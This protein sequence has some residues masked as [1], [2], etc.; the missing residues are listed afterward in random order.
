ME[1]TKR[2]ICRTCLLIAFAL[3]LLQSLCGGYAFA[4]GELVS[5]PMNPEFLSYMEA[6]QKERVMATGVT[7]EG[8]GLGLVPS[9]LNLDYL[10][11]INIFGAPQVQ[12]LAEAPLRLG[13][14][15]SYDLRTQGK[16]TPVRDQSTG[17]TCWTFATYGSV[18][19][20]LL[21]GETDDFSENHMKNTHGFDWGYDSGGNGDMA[22]A[23]LARWSGPVNEADDTYN[24]GSG[25]SPPG[26]LPRKHVQG[27]IYIPQR[28]SSSDNDNL[29]N[30][31]MSAGAVYATMYISQD[32]SYYNEGTYAYYY[33][34]AS[35]SNHAVAIV[36]WDDNYSS[37]NFPSAPPGNGAFI[38]RNSWG[39]GFG[40]GG[41]FYISYYDTK[42]AYT[43]NYLFYNTE[44]VTNY[45]RIYQYDPL[46]WTSQIGYSSETGW[47]A[48]IFT[49]QASESLVAVSF[50][51]TSA[52]SPYEIYIYTGV[53]AGVP[54]SGTLAA[55]ETG[56]IQ[57]P[58]Y[59]TIDL[60]SPVYLASGG[61]FS[62]V[63]KL[64]APGT[65]YPISL[66]HWIENYSGSA[67]ASAGQSFISSSGSPWSDLTTLGT[68]DKDNVCLKGFTTEA[69][70][71]LYA[72]WASGLYQENGN[73]WS[74]LHAM[75]PT[76][77][78]ASGSALYATWASGL[79]QWNGTT[80][81][82]IHAAV[83]TNMAA[84]GPN[85]YATWASGLYA[86]N[87][88]TWTKIHA[89]VP[90]AMTAGNNTLYAT[91]ASG[92]YQWNGITWT[93]IH[94]AVPTGMA[95]G[96]TNLYATWAS[97]LYQ[98]NGITWTKIHAAVPT[99]MVAGSANLYATWPSGL[100]QWNGSAWSKLHATVPSSMTAGSNTIYAAWASGLFQWNGSTWSRLHSTEPTNIKAGN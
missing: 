7:H 94:A 53:T 27:V 30:A 76:S 95:A 23:Y 61:R 82:K 43:T 25:V 21:T 16:L 20:N 44:P 17:N 72:T 12:E 77:M 78:A 2:N 55:T 70:S 54:R 66:E 1:K 33:Y 22:T 38:V 81:T 32:A 49:A 91:W 60:S 86:W 24:A 67:T 56:T 58:G 28:T 3:M 46:G 98:W 96:S 85:L 8:R 84:S 79:Y 45:S 40:D 59:T 89:A 37:A 52:N 64:T 63:V 14:P 68:H 93:K 51:N 11:G 15:V 35:G 65:N 80:W 71:P 29:K 57:Y 47:F 75:V 73:T 10:A 74:K 90:T 19:S 92:L 83:P 4:E 50:H 97:G 34:G 39:S 69:S 88:I 100:F 48:N 31:V 87:G 62:I 18:E 36:G 13:F 99:G 6:L 5:A 26:L 42:L 9:P 41:Y